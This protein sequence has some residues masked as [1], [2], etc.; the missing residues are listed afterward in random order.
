MAYQAY[1]AVADSQEAAQEQNWVK[2]GNFQEETVQE[3]LGQ[4]VIE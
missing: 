4:G 2:E 3:R 1:L